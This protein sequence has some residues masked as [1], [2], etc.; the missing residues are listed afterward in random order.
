VS[1]F[2]KVNPTR[3][4][5]VLRITKIKSIRFLQSF[6]SSWKL[7]LEPYSDIA[8]SDPQVYS[9]ATLPEQI[10]TGTYIVKSRDTLAKIADSLSGTVSSGALLEL[11]P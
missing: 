8:C 9:G 10:G 3:F 2:N 11:N 5:V 7:Y 6:H 1:V 4:D